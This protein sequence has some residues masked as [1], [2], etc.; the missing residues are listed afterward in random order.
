[1]RRARLH[2]RSR[3]RTT[4]LAGLVAAVLTLSACTDGSSDDG[5]SQAKSAP[6]QGSQAKPRPKPKPEPKPKP[7]WRQRPTSIAALG[8][9]ITRGFDACKPLA[10][11]PQVSW[12][13]GTD[14]QVDS[15]AARLGAKQRWNFARTGAQVADLPVQANEA[16]ARKPELI[17]ILI[18][19]NDACRPTTAGMTSVGTFRTTVADSLRSIR[20][21]LPKTQVYVASVPDLERLWEVGKDNPV[22]QQIWKLGIC[23]SMLKSPQASTT[24]DDGRR[25]RVRDR[26]R[27]FNR[28][29][30]EECAKV[31]L[32]RFDGNATFQYDFS[33]ADLS[34]WDYFHPSKTGQA[35]LAE[36]AYR[37][38]TSR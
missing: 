4:A 29:L 35:S 25:G 30:R 22:T 10:D 3:T 13:T 17:S 34:K 24:A 21:G 16:I 37:K 33:V 18:G 1:M 26:V 36:I 20:K 14:A 27:E 5:G 28:V 8:D 7:A 2:R 12:A 6:D 19:A 32:C 11:C 38:V 31:S 9:S 15:L 23:Q